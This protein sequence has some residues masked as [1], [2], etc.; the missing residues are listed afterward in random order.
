MLEITGFFT[1]LVDVC[2]EFLLALANTLDLLQTEITL[3]YI[4]ESV[5]YPK[6]VPLVGGLV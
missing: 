5:K 4:T 2:L 6:K 3:D 1:A